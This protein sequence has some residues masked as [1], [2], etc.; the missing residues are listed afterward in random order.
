LLCSVLFVEQRVTPALAPYISS[1]PP[2]PPPPR[3]RRRRR[4]IQPRTTVFEHQ[5]PVH[6]LLQQEEM[7]GFSGGF[8]GSRRPDAPRGPPLPM[9]LMNMYS[10]PP[11]PPPPAILLSQKNRFLPR[12]PV[13]YMKPIHKKTLG[14]YTG[15]ARFAHHVTIACRAA[16]SLRWQLRQLG[17]LRVEGGVAAVACEASSAGD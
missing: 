7:S 11:L 6:F 13:E 2:P 5:S 8:A 4:P 3:R 1:P 16:H 15:V 14:P 17:Q 9:H 10:P 12:P